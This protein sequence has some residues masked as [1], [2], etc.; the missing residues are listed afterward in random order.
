MVLSTVL[1]AFAVGMVFAARPAVNL[2]GEWTVTLGADSAAHSM[3]L[4][5]TTDSRGLGTATEPSRNT[6]NLA[7][8]HTFGGT[9]VYSRTFEVPQ[10]HGGAEMVL[11]L[12]RCRPSTVYVDGVCIGSANRLSV[13][14]R[15][16][17]GSLS[18]GTH[19]LRIEVNNADSIPDAVRQNSHE[20]TESTQTVWNGILGEIRIDSRG[21]VTLDS[22]RVRPDVQGSRFLLTA[23]TRGQGSVTAGLYAPD[24]TEVCSREAE[25]GHL[26]FELPVG[27]EAELW[28][29]FSPR[30]YRLLLTS[31][32]D[33]L[34]ERSIGLRDFRAGADGHF[35]INGH[36]TFLRGRHDACVW[37]LTA[38][39]PLDI[40]PWR[41]YFAIVRSYGL[42]HVR[43]HS[44]C[45]PEAAFQAAD[46]AGVYLQPELP[47]W[48]AVDG[49]DPALM[50][51]LRD[52][53]LDIVREYSHHP[54]FVM[55]SLGNELWGEVD[56]MRE[57]ADS[58]RAA[59]PDLL[60]ALGSNIFLGWKG[61]QQG[62]D[63]MV[64][65]RVGGGD[66]FST[67]ARAS[68][69]F[70][71][72]DDGGILNHTRPNTDRDFS[73]A[74]ALSP[75]P[76]VGHETGQ[77]QIY[78]NFAERAKYTGV[79]RPDNL[80][81]FHRRVDSIGIAG[82]ADDY[83]RAS[84]AWAVELYK[85][86]IE[87][88][89]RTPAMGGFQLLDLQDYPG[90]G[91]AL[92]G[93]LDAFM[94]S[95]NLVT[96]E[97]WRGFCSEVVPMA[98]FGDYCRHAGDSI[99]IRSAIANYSGASLAG[100]RLDVVV[101]IPAKGKII[102]FALDVPDGEGL[103]D[104]SPVALV[105]P[106]SDAP[107]ACDIILKI[108][109]TDISNSYTVWAMPEGRPN[110]ADYGVLRADSL[111]SRALDVLA[112]GGIVLLTPD[113]AAC[114]E[115]SVGPLYQTDYWNYRMFRTI[116]ESAGRPVS[117]GTLGLFIDSVHPSLADFPTDF[118]ADRQWFGIVKNSR[119][120]IMDS[121]GTDFRPVVEVIDNVERN[122]RLALLAE[123]R[124][125]EG[126]V[127][128]APVDFDKA[129]DTPEG[130]A[131]FTSIL[132]YMVS[133]AFEPAQRIDPAALAG[134]LRG[135]RRAESMD[136]LENVSYH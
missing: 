28:S 77:Y 122:H 12:E 18:A 73:G 88:N 125:G 38:H 41:R 60:Y 75:V 114:A 66:G 26:D 25:S 83:F 50:N 70:A 110:P 1:T 89:L 14:Q 15:F 126:R 24:G 53:G 74:V 52:E 2:A 71:D 136:R 91:T 11:T 120:I 27:S 68:F 39:V 56:S 127:V 8:R 86:D 29:E 95:K 99:V 40:E 48:G 109:G 4:P 108:E 81:E 79:L 97:R 10:V 103:L 131:W 123:F 3:V 55:F 36:P 132:R 31:G 78:P 49:S 65:C 67:H 59:E 135:H 23:R 72:A 111:G 98:R 20:C 113:S 93:I 76:V 104:L 84:G 45:P 133:P 21:A 6:S 105:L 102:S 42:N 87:M 44:W 30:L 43:F 94:D 58:F 47:V 22:L 9:A 82:R 35:Q 51:F 37:P 107:Y 57:L 5:G 64:T 118:H 117:P 85:D 63:F 119:P 130:A 101:E 124:V 13:P 17:L 92:V 61:H 7:R 32:E 116:C 121:L 129:C 46:E 96:P 69:S 112:A 19:T 62:E 16:E 115:A 34:A 80:D 33:T 134:L 128:L 100:Q 54:S 106:E 90:Q